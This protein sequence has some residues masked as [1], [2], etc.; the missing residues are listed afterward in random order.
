MASST[1]AEVVPIFGASWIYFFTVVTV[2]IR[3]LSNQS[4]SA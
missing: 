3:Q 4:I 2:R 1:G